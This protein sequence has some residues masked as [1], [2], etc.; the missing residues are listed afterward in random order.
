MKSKF[1]I[2]SYDLVLKIMMKFIAVIYIR[3]A[4]GDVL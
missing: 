1:E 4:Y 3:L 2:F